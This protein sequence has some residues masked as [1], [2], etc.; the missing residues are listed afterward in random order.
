MSADASDLLGMIDLFGE[1]DP[2]ADGGGG[3]YE[4][5]APPAEV[6]LTNDVAT[7]NSNNNNG[8][9]QKRMKPVPSTVPNLFSVSKESKETEYRHSALSSVWKEP[10]TGYN[11]KQRSNT[12]LED[13]TS[14]L[15]YYSL[16]KMSEYSHKLRQETTSGWITAGI[17]TNKSSSEKTRQGKSFVKLYLSDLNQTDCLVMLFDQAFDSHYQ[18]IDVGSII[19][20]INPKILDSQ[21]G[22]DYSRLALS[23]TSPGCVILIGASADL[24]HCK[25]TTKSGSACTVP[26]N[27]FK[28]NG[29]CK[30]HLTQATKVA[31]AAVRKA[32]GQSASNR[33]PMTV[34]STPIPTNALCSFVQRNPATAPGTRSQPKVTQPMIRSDKGKVVVPYSFRLPPSFPGVTSPI[35][36]LRK[37]EIEY[38]LWRNEYSKALAEQKRTKSSSASTSSI[39]QTQVS[40]KPVS[41]YSAAVTAKKPDVV[42]TKSIKDPISQSGVCSSQIPSAAKT[43]KKG[44]ATQQQRPTGVPT[45]AEQMIALRAGKKPVREQVKEKRKSEDVP[46]S[47]GKRLQLSD[48]L[49]AAVKVDRIERTKNIIDSLADKEELLNE[50]ASVKETLVTAFKCG[51]CNIY[52]QSKDNCCSKAN[53]PHPLVRCSDVPK[54][55]WQCDTCHMRT[56]VISP[57]RIRPQISCNCSTMSWSQT[58]MTRESHQSALSKMSATG[59]DRYIR[60]PYG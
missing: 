45:Y 28:N 46:T 32:K 49:Q 56:A 19:A 57:A 8:N 7:S 20:V 43:S 44:P 4:P 24:A 29:F 30:Y 21:G 58:G 5:I 11:L 22:T 31:D 23:I 12:S 41:R 9:F 51:I 1:D 33:P 25:G 6:R 34:L 3:S 38:E 54:R 18:R 52:H 50:M 15:T 40:Q 17:V 60:N 55:F 48:E 14:E 35:P 53:P 13:I 26:V 10:V 59:E 47:G 39:P 16:S 36:E 42:Q 2:G 37:F 27:A